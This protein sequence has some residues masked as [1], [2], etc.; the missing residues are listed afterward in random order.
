MLLLVIEHLPQTCSDHC[1]ILLS[2]EPDK[3]FNCKPFNLNTWLSDLT[4]YNFIHA[5]WASSAYLAS[6][7]NTGCNFNT[8]LSS[9]TKAIIK[10]NRECFGHLAHR[11][12]RILARLKGIQIVLANNPS[13]FLYNLEHLTLDYKEILSQEFLFWQLNSRGCQY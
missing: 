2:C 13:F 1:P 12:S 11:K 5:H 8:C 4:F 6:S 10:W 9:L 7:S 3:R